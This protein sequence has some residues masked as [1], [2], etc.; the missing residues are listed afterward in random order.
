MLLI[1][2]DMFKALWTMIF[3][4]VILTQGPISNE[5]SPFCQAHRFFLALSIEAS[6]TALLLVLDFQANRVQ[7]LQ[8]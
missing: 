7:I 8:F 6:G 2:S 1:Q 4:A 3:P 5:F